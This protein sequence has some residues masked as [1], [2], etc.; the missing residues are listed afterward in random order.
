MFYFF[1]HVLSFKCVLDFQVVLY[2]IIYIYI[3]CCIC[4]SSV[5][6]QAGLYD[7][8]FTLLLISKSKVRQKNPARPG[9]IA[10]TRARQ[11]SSLLVKST[12]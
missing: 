5:N 11:M 4:I 10:R 12:G 3:Y 1:S 7:M 6:A 2:I 9:A 8:N